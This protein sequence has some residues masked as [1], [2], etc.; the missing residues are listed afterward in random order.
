MALSHLRTALATRIKTVANVGVVNDWEPYTTRDEDFA[1][2][3]KSG[4]LLRGWTITRESTR[5]DHLTMKDDWSAHL[6]VIR[7]YQGV[8]NDAASEKTFQDLVELVRAALRLEQTAR[9][10]GYANRVQHPQ[11]R[12]L[13]PR[14]FAGVFVHYVEI[15]LIVEEAL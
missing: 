4:A 15:S 2:F 1:A 10:S 12:I 6:M 13:E 3:F 7:G 5:E 8:D 11:V 14:L 9:L